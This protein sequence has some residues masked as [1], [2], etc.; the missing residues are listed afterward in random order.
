MATY[1]SFL[2]GIVPIV[3]GAAA[4]TGCS[5]LSGAR[6]AWH[7]HAW[8]ARPLPVASAAEDERM[9]ARLSTLEL[10]RGALRGRI[11]AE[12][13][14]LQRQ[15]LYAQLHEVGTELS[16]LQRQLFSVQR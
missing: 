6:D 15:A 5:S 7:W 3:L 13:D 8:E 11:S 14:I 12:P 4:L 1:R 9:T 16:I 2:S 10:E